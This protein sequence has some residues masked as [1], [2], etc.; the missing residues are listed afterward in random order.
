MTR[1]S[2]GRSRTALSAVVFH[3]ID[4]AI[5]NL[6]NLDS[7]D[8]LTA[9]LGRCADPDLALRSLI[10]LADVAPDRTALLTALAHDE[11][12][13]MRLLQVLGASSAL[14]EHLVRH[15]EHWAELTDP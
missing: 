15:P 5:S 10:R 11:G 6:R 9:M 13:A 1:Q 4:E 3:E 8:A 12:T 2:F 7:G 14:G